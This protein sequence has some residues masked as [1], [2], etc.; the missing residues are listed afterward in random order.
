MQFRYAP[1]IGILIIF[2]FLKEQCPYQFSCIL[3]VDFGCICSIVVSGRYTDV[4]FVKEYFTLPCLKC[5][6]SVNTVNRSCW[7]F[8]NNLFFRNITR[9]SPTRQ[10]FMEFTCGLSAQGSTLSCSRTDRPCWTLNKR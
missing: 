9:A 6:F 1:F 3:T 10:D 4:Q 5:G 7:I 8:L 2:H